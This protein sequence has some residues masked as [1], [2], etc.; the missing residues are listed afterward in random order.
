MMFRMSINC[1]IALND[2]VNGDLASFVLGHGDRL[3]S[4]ATGLWFFPIDNCDFVFVKA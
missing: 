3:L 2:L 4:Y 1:I